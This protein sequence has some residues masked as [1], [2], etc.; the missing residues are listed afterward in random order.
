MNLN[1]RINFKLS[2][3]D[4]VYLRGFLKHGLRRLSQSEE[5]EQIQ[6][7]YDRLQEE[8]IKS[9]YETES[10]LENNDVKIF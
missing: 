1:Q 4:V 3:E 6:R 2:A 9:Q 7:I 10:Q 8:V 5:R